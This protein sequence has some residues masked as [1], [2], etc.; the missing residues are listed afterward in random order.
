M[1]QKISVPDGIEYRSVMNIIC[2]VF[3]LTLFELSY[4]ITCISKKVG[5]VGNLGPERENYVGNLVSSLEQKSLE[6]EPGRS[7]PE[8]VIALS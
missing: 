3:S 6:E 5:R 8:S 4:V 1:V 7:L 2:P